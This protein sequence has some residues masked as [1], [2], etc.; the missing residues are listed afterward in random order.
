MHLYNYAKAEIL[1]SFD[2]DYD[3]IRRDCESLECINKAL[4]L[5]S[6]PIRTTL[7]NYTKAKILESLDTYDE[8]LEC[9]NKVLETSLEYN[10]YYISIKIDILHSLLRY[11]ELFECID[12]ALESRRDDPKHKIYL[13]AKKSK[14]IR[15]SWYV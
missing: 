7:Y 15:T 10:L 2:R 1:Q 13:L 5:E 8:A 4:E 6:D 3:A 11:D 9:I 14:Y 12:Q